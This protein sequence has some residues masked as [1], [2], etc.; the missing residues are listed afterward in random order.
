MCSMRLVENH[1]RRLMRDYDICIVRNQFFRMVIID[2]MTI[3]IAALYKI[4][5]YY[6][7]ED[8]ILA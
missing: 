4:L 1:N 7:L 6:K 2:K 3:R 5:E 8:I